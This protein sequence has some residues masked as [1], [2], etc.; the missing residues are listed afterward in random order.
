[1]KS[2]RTLR[3]SHSSSK[4]SEEEPVR[5]ETPQTPVKESPSVSLNFEASPANVPM[6]GPMTRT[7]SCSSSLRVHHSSPITVPIAS[8]ETT[9]MAPDTPSG[10]GAFL[11]GTVPDSPAPLQ[12]ASVQEAI[13]RNA[14]KESSCSA[15]PDDDIDVERFPT[16]MPGTNLS[17]E[18]MITPGIMITSPSAPYMQGHD[19]PD[20]F[21][22]VR[23]PAEHDYERTKTLDTESGFPTLDDASTDVEASILGFDYAVVPGHATIP[24][25]EPA[26]FDQFFP[27]APL[28]D[29]L[30]S[31][32]SKKPSGSNDYGENVAYIVYD[33]LSASD[34]GQKRKACPG[35][36]GR[37]TSQCSDHPRYDGTGYGRRE[38]TSSSH[39]WTDSTEPSTTDSAELTQH[40]SRGEAAA[41]SKLMAA[42]EDLDVATLPARSQSPVDDKNCLQGII[43]AYAHV[44]EGT[45]DGTGGFLFAERPEGITQEIK[46]EVETSI[47]VMNRSLGG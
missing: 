18:D 4:K 5:I 33:T 39:Y 3:L 32:A 28:D 7:T 22:G 8:R 23:V 44:G 24:E 13:I 30:A 27:V 45:D 2:L 6:F 43:R 21:D 37:L 19:P 34:A 40:S 20:Y 12:R 9:P 36:W 47:R 25:V 14:T 16:P 1:M 29:S 46:D 42:M 35:H 10:L 15:S 31:S 26:S 11:I 41:S 17:L 38:A